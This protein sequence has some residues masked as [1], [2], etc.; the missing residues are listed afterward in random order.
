MGAKLPDDALV[1]GEEPVR[2]CHGR[3]CRERPARRGGDSGSNAMNPEEA[4]AETFA[5][6][7][8]TNR[9]TSR[10]PMFPVLAEA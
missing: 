5:L 6:S 10:W 4:P 2:E 7:G 1:V 8:F 3:E 9:S